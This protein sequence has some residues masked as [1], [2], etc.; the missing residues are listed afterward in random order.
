MTSGG[1]DKWIELHRRLA[2]PG[3]ATDARESW[4]TLAE[5]VRQLC[6]GFLRGRAEEIEEATQESLLAIARAMRREGPRAEQAMFAWVR[7]VARHECIRVTNPRSKVRLVTTQFVEGPP[8]SGGIES[9][10]A[11]LVPRAATS[12]E[13]TVRVRTTLERLDPDCRRILVLRMEGYR[14]AEIAEM[15]RQ[16]LAAAQKKGQRCE[17]KFVTVYTE[18]SVGTTRP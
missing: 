15:R 5:E 7:T 17:E 11:M 12:S 3:D 14:Y 2:G 16:P 4:R 1:N 8:S 6:R 13:E 10:P 18:L 9:G